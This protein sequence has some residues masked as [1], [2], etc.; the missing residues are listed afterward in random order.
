M[1]CTLT[2]NVSITGLMKKQLRPSTLGKRKLRRDWG[3]AHMAAD[4]D[5]SGFK[6][7]G[8]SERAQEEHLEVAKK[9]FE[10]GYVKQLG[11]VA[12]TMSKV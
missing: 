2:V 5:T 1:P 3:S 4:A 11:V 9:M 8:R 7:N 12:V 6:H 10:G